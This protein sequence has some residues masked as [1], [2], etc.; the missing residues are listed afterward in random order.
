MQNISLFYNNYIQK[1]QID[2]KN[3]IDKKRKNELNLW[4]KLYY[5]Q[6]LIINFLLWRH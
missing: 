1:T 6:L 5:Y 4:R 3:Y 2:A